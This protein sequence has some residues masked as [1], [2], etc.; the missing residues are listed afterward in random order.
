MFFDAVTPLIKDKDALTDNSFTATANGVAVNTKGILDGVET[1]YFSTATPGEY[2]IV[3]TSVK[4]P[5]VN[6]TITVKVEAAPT[7]EEI[8]SG[9][10]VSGENYVLFGADNTVTIKDNAA[11]VVYSYTYDAGNKTFSLTK[12]GDGVNAQDRKSV[13]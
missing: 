3:L 8:C 10:Y 9:K 5:D 6:T 2:T 1:A 13:V 12:T 11:A 4:S 7:A